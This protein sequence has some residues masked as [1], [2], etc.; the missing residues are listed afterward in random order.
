MKDEFGF[1]VIDGSATI[2]TQQAVVRDMVSQTID[3]P[4]YRWKTVR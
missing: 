1:R 4:R 3:L 2:E